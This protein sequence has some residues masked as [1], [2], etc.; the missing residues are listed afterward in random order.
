MKKYFSKISVALLFLVA[1]TSCQEDIV[2]YDAVNGKAL[3]NFLKPAG[4]L[5][6]LEATES[7]AKIK[8]NV[9]TISTV[10]RAIVIAIDEASTATPNQYTIDQASLVVP[11]GKHTAEI[12]VTGN[13][14]QVDSDKYHLLINL[15]SVGNATLDATLKK[16]DLTIFKTCPFDATLVANSSYTGSAYKD[17]FASNNYIADFYPVITKTGDR[18]FTFDSMWGTGFVAAITQNPQY[19]GQYVYSGKIIVEDDLTLTIIPTDDNISGSGGAG[20]YDPCTNTF[21]Y[22]LTEDIFSAAF[23]VYVTLTPNN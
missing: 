2:K 22:V 9:S 17:S 1:F 7:V 4:N 13:F 8:I 18:E 10:D 19:D 20:T 12:I 23:P 3:A 6:V 16:F 5:P 11:A 15:V 14:S 21:T